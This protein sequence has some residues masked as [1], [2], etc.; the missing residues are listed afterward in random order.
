REV[1]RAIGADSRIGPKFLQAGP[2]FGGSCFQKDILNLVYLCRHYGLEEVAAYWEQ[3][4]RLNTWQQHRIAKLVVNRLFG[5]VSGKRIGVLG[6]AFKADTNDTRESPA[7]RICRDLLEEGAILQ[8]V[9]PKVSE[10][11]MVRDLGQPAGEASG[12]PSAEGCWHQVSDVQ[13]AA[14]GADALVLLT[15]WQQFA[16]IDWPAAAAVMRQPAW[17]FDARAKADAVNARA[18]GLQVWTVGE[19]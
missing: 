7:I 5:T 6:F 17:L 3:V 8:I 9:D 16:Q 13:Q 19:G 12:D 18:A 10:A 1:A 15:E 4:V 14:S 2:G 11:Q